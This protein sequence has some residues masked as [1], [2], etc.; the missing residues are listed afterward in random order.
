MVMWL[1]AAAGSII[2]AGGAYWFLCLRYVALGDSLAAG[3]GSFT[4]FGYVPRYALSLMWR[5]RRIVLTTNLGRFGLTSGQLLAA[6]RAD[7]QF[8][9]AVRRAKLITIDI[10]GNDLLHCNYQEDCLERALAEFR[11]NWEAILA[12]VRTLNPAAVLFAI[13]LYNPVPAGDVRRPSVD[14]VVRRL[15]GII[16]LP[17]LVRTYAV[18]GVAPV[19]EQFVGHECEFTWFC[20]IGD[21][22]PTD[23]GHEIIVAALASLGTPAIRWMQFPFVR[24]LRRAGGEL[25]SGGE[26]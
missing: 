22:H 17:S 9:G 16:A 13:T 11:T 8:R 7:Q 1:L 2:A 20:R 25:S 26:Q 24:R 18:S 23:R 12:E 19:Y 4:F 5:L 15:N 6:L 21:I 3:V 14:K 10:G